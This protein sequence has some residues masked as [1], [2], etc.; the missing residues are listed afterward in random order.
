MEAQ[1]IGETLGGVQVLVTGGTGH[2]GRRLVSALLTCGADVAV[3]TRSY[4]RASGHFRGLERPVDIRTG[5]ITQKETLSSTLRGIEIVFHLASFSPGPRAKGSVYQHPAHWQVTAVGTANILDAARAAGCRRLIYFSSVKAMGEEAGSHGY[6]D[7]ETSCLEPETLYGR[8]KLAAERSIMSAAANGHIEATVLRLPMVY[9]LGAA[10]NLDRMIEGI[11]RRRFPP[12]PPISNR[13]SAIHA[14]D[15]IHAA[16]QAASSSHASGR[17][18]LVTDGEGYS[19]R[20]IYEQIHAGL[21]R[22][23]PRWSLPVWCWKSAATI[24]TFAE[25]TLAIRSPLT[26]ESFAKLFGNAWFSS[27]RIEDE[28]GFHAQFELGSTI[29]AMAERSLD[30]HYR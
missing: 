10:G 12:F 26:R 14:L 16:L 22:K 1:R 6:P 19:T 7:D 24:G 8:S 20:W 21:G 4:R 9:G 29:R 27:R 25:Q 17:V 23:V 30:E 11:S 15:A 18:Y 13:R 5:D 3:L 2:I 28:L